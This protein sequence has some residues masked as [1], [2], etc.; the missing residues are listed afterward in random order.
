MFL[1]RERRGGK[2]LEKVVSC[3]AESRGKGMESIEEFEVEDMSSMVGRVRS[4]DPV[5]AFAA[6]V[7]RDYLRG[8]HQDLVC[9]CS[10]VLLANVMF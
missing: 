10:N 8:I 1:Q 2:T 3:R 6:Q 9:E 7:L 5:V 4:G